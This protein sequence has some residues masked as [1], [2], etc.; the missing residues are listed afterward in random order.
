MAALIV[1]STARRRTATLFNTQVLDVVST[2]NPNYAD[3]KEVS[4]FLM[5]PNSLPPDMA[6]ALYVSIGGWSRRRC[7]IILQLG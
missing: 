4:L 7:L 2:V 6:L 3:L 5:Q 1:S